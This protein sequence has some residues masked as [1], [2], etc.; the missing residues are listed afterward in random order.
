MF[1]KRLTYVYEGIGKQRTRY[2]GKFE[3]YE[4]NGRPLWSSH[5]ENV[6][7]LVAQ[8]MLLNEST[9]TLST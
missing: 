5:I 6:V 3:K 8:P 4:K 7:I 2:V 1:A 9:T